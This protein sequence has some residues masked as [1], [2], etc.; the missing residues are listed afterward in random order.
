MS[1]SDNP[2]VVLFFWIGVVFALIGLLVSV[3]RAKG[4]KAKLIALGIHALAWIIG[5]F[6]VRVFFVIILVVIAA[7]F[8]TKGEI[9]LPILNA[10]TTPSVSGD[11]IER[12]DLEERKREDL[13][14]RR[15][16]VKQAVIRK[17]GLHPSEVHVNSTADRVSI[18]GEWK[19]V[20]DL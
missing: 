13:E 20:S 14:K 4:G 5:Y 3:L 15:E 9:L 2:D 8:F 17:Y 12:E 6:A 16:A 1:V 11:N 19:K 18:N 7:A 10:M